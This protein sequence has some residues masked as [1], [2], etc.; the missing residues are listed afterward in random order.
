MGIT[1]AKSLRWSR[2]QTPLI[3]ETNAT[4]TGMAT[5]GTKQAKERPLRSIRTGNRIQDLR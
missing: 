2:F 4:W 3:I 5:K 1:A